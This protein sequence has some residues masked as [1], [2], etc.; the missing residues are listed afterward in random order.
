MKIF[1]SIRTFKLLFL[2][3]IEYIKRNRLGLILVGLG[4]F[5]FALAQ[6]KLAP[7]YD[8]NSISLGFIGTYQEHDLPPPVTKL[9]SQSLSLADDSGRIKGNLVTGW[10]TNNDATIFKFKLK[11]GIK[12]TDG[13][14]V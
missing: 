2:V 1:L 6:V 7:F 14:K 12:W 3:A 4:V 5:L 10:E 13:S 9:I 11:D 8:S